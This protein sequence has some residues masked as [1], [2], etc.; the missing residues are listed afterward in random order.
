MPFKSKAQMKW[1]YSN[2]PQMADE[3]AAHTKSMSKLPARKTYDGKGTK[4]R[5]NTYAEK[6]FF[7]STS[8]K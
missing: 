6:S 8:S 4:A 1:M 7:K 5:L 2:K 3:W